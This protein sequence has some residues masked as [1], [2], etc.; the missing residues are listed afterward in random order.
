MA[1]CSSRFCPCLSTLP[2]SAW[3]RHLPAPLYPAH[4]IWAAFLQCCLMTR[5][6]HRRKSHC[7]PSRGVSALALSPDHWCFCG[8]WLNSDP[9][10]EELS[11]LWTLSLNNDS[12]SKVHSWKKRAIFPIADHFA[13]KDASRTVNAFRTN[14]TAVSVLY[15]VITWVTQNYVIRVHRS[16]H[17]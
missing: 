16:F 17:C 7:L 10:I 13:V 4:V 3:R 8:Y 1:C 11:Y 5:S 9:D 12:G 2:V 6:L 15:T 14:R